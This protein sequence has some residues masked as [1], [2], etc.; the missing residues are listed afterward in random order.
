MMDFETRVVRIEDARLPPPKR[1]YGEIVITAKRRKGQLILAHVR[2][3][4]FPLDAV[5][6]TGSQ[7]TIGNMALRAKLFRAHPERFNKT[8]IVGVTGVP[9]QLGIVTVEELQLGPVILYDVPI[10]FADLPPFQ[11]FGLSNEPA[12]LLGTDILEN[13]R[14]V[15]LDF[16][17]RKVRFQLRRC[18]AQPFQTTATLN[19]RQASLMPYKSTEACLR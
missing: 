12:L 14:R 19:Q 8:I 10:A 1:V 16:G 4:G 9:V 7:I 6:D 11:V 15:S 17:S 13:F 5:I 3:G 18:A 2:A